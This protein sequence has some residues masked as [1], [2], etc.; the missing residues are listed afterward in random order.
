MNHDLHLPN[1]RIETN[2][3]NCPSHIRRDMKI[4]KTVDS[5]NLHDRPSCLLEMAL[6]P[7]RS[8][9]FSTNESAEFDA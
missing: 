5:L 4:L 8:P 9:R 7:I 2:S 1:H 3:L 6:D